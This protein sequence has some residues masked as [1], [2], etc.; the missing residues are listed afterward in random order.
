[1]KYL[2]TDIKGKEEKLKLEEMGLYCYDLRDSDDDRD[3]A[4]IEKHVIVNRIGTMITNKEI[5]LGDKYP[6]DFVD[7]NT[8]V[9]NEDNKAVFT[10]QELLEK[11]K[12]KEND[13][14]GR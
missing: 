2:I 12:V 8:F 5:K 4:S 3:V 1:M 14:G 7:Y 10:I 11:D 6:N 9:N 13:K